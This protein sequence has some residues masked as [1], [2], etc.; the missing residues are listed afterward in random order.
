M[1]C[2]IRRV[3]NHTSYVTRLYN[4]LINIIQIPSVAVVVEAAAHNEF[5]GDAESDVM[6]GQVGFVSLGFHGHGGHTYVLCAGFGQYLVQVDVGSAS[7]DDV[8]EDDD[9][10]TAH[11]LVETDEAVDFAGGFS[12]AIR[13]EFHA[14]DSAFDVEL[15]D[16][17]DGE[18]DSTVQ[19][20]QQN[21]IVVAVFFI[22][23]GG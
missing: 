11:V 18:E 21:G 20:N 17:I 5:V 8:F 15:L 1:T 9:P 6:D 13:G 4:N 22:D 23:F 10:L 7:I 19:C 2:D 12:A 16:E 3:K 14:G